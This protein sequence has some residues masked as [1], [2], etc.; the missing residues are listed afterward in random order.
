MQRCRRGQG[1]RLVQ[2]PEQLVQVAHD[3]EHRE[4]LLGDLRGLP[5]VV[6]VVDV[7][8]NL[9]TGTEAVVH[10]ATREP[11]RPKLFVDRASKV[12]LEVRA[13]LT[14]GLVDGEVGR[15][16]ERRDDAAQPEALG[17]VSPKVNWEL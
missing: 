17:A 16:G 5:P 4:H 15:G 8:R 7:L 6:P 12:G 14:G 3:R 9:L 11:S 1:K 13:R 2:V 10:G